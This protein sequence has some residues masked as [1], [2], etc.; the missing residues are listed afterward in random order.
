MLPPKETKDL[1]EKLSNDKALQETST[2]EQAVI[3]M[4]ANPMSDKR[5]KEL[6]DVFDKTPENQE[7]SVIQDLAANN[8]K[9]KSE[10]AEWKENISPESMAE[11]KELVDEYKEI[12]KDFINT[13]D[14]EEYQEE[15]LEIGE[16]ISEEMPDDL[17]NIIKNAID[18]NSKDQIQNLKGIEPAVNLID[19]SESK[20]P[21][22][23][24]EDNNFID[25]KG[26]IGKA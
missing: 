20:T 9:Y 18:G 25:S 4:K 3:D 16:K 2:L 24:Q 5:M 6:D 10:L 26:D 12:V 7:L 13:G 17:E 23:I 11:I 8:A 14:S 19:E 1:E 21:S 15:M 22:A